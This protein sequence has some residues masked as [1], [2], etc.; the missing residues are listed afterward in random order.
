MMKLIPFKAIVGIGALISILIGFYVVYLVGYRSC[1]VDFKVAEAEAMEL[2]RQKIIKTEA[3]YDQAR[4]NIRQI[5][6][7][8]VPAGPATTDAI[9]SLRRA[10][11]NGK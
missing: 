2:A 11:S 6:G 1:K 8:E 9:D 4:E 3:A 5:K 10:K 7:S